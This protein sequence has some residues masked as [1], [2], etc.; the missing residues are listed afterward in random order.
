MLFNSLEYLIFLPTVAVLYFALPHKVRWVLLLAASYFF[1]MSWRPDFAVLI[2]ISTGIDYYAGL[3]MGKQEEKAKRKKWLYLSLFVNLGMLCSFK[4]LD[5]LN[6]T[7]R[8]V[9]GIFGHEYPVG[10]F[11]ILLPIGI[12][13]YT[14]QTL[15]YT[16]DV[17]RG[18]KKAE[19]HFGI[20]ATYVAFFPQLVGGP[21]ETS[22]RFL[23]QFFDKHVF[24]V[25]A[26]CG[27]HQT[28]CLGSV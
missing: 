17:Y 27:R 10:H 2:L 4:Y 15:S 5:F 6:E 8:D 19:K 24:R 16:I 1:Y 23:P 25:A 11:D 9:F 21:I 26:S 22:T 12:S 3:Q 7:V 13:Y 14:F 18:N 20:F 28:H